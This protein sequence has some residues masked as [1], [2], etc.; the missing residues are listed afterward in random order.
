MYSELSLLF[1]SNYSSLKALNKYLFVSIN[2]Y[3]WEYLNTFVFIFILSGV[4]PSSNKTLILLIKLFTP[5][6]CL[7][8]DIRNCSISFVKIS[9]FIESPQHSYA[10]KMTGFTKKSTSLRYLRIAFSFDLLKIFCIENHV[11]LP[12]LNQVFNANIFFP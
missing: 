12:F 11:F 4:P 3:I 7:H 5:C 10:Y 1:V 8:I 2:E 9:F 6:I